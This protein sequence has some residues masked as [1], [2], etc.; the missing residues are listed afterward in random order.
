MLLNVEVIHGNVKYMF[1]T[2]SV[3]LAIIAELII[4]GLFLKKAL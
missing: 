2:V 3:R 4:M 1:L